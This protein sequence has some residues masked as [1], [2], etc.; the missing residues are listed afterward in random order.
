[1]KEDPE[2]KARR[3]RNLRESFPVPLNQIA[4]RHV[5]TVQSL[6]GNRKA[7]LAKALAKV[8]VDRIAACLAVIKSSGDSIKTESD[9]IATL[10]LSEIPIDT[11]S[12][13]NNIDASS[14]A[15]D[16]EEIDTDY[17]A[18]LLIKCYPD[19]PQATADALV[20]SEVMALSLRVVSTT[21]LA[22]QD[23]KSD[24]VITAL[25]TLF[26][27]KLDEI[28]RVIANNPAFVKAMQLSRPD[29]KPN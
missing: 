29:W 2:N 27:E 1:M 8:G 6:N 16:L 22:L 28:E 19:M 13:D 14:V 5:D 9:L 12:K 23:A 4:L 17:L 26:E 21:R 24:F 7:I 15:Q 3:R 11:N 25:Y 20:G 18:S 10:R